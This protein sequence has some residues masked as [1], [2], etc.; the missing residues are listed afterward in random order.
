VRGSLYAI[1]HRGSE[2]SLDDMNY[3]ALDGDQAPGPLPMLLPPSS[4]APYAMAPDLALHSDLTPIKAWWIFCLVGNALQIFSSLSIMLDGRPTG[5]TVAMTV[6]G[7]GALMA[8]VNLVRYFEFS[9]RFYVLV[10]T[11]EKSM[12][13][14]A[15]FLVSSVPILLGFAVMGMAIFGAS[16]KE[17]STLQLSI[18]TLFALMNGDSVLQMLDE[19]NQVPWTGIIFLFTFLLLFICAVMN[20]FITIVMHSYECVTGYHKHAHDAAEAHGKASQHSQRGDHHLHLHNRV[21]E[22]SRE[23]CSR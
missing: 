7:L 16:T 18:E 15:R 23:T 22:E 4:Q 11:L 19:G 3:E 10:L 1:T 9:G 13:D 12:P 8:W 2:G 5:G 17:F 20:I 14:I 21:H 6:L